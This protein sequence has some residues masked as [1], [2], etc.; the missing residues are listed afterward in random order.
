MTDDLYQ[1]YLD[2]IDWLS[3][4]VETAPEARAAAEATTRARLESIEARRRAETDQLTERLGRAKSSYRRVA[5]VLD[6]PDLAN[7]GLHLPA[8]LTPA[9][10]ASGSLEEAEYE[11][12]RAVVALV[13]AVNN[14]RVRRA[15]EAESAREAAEALAARRAALEA[16][17]NQPPPRRFEPRMIVAVGVIAVLLIVI[18]VLV[19]M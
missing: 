14:H 1:T 12:E 13:G 16:A 15:A 3:T 4:A 8:S 7:L 5:G 18:I 17:R 9:P 19:V 6:E 11:Q 2:A 10:D